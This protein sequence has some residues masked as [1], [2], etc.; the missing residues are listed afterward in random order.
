MER[1]E[2]LK[3]FAFKTVLNTESTNKCAICGDYFYLLRSS[4]NSCNICKKVLIIVQ[5][6]IRIIFE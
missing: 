2:N 4:P 5:I 3:N 1:L 6:S